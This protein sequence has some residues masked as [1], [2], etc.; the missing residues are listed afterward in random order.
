M[1]HA[2]TVFVIVLCCR[3]SPI[4]LHQILQNTTDVNEL[5]LLGRIRMA[6][7]GSNGDIPK[8]KVFKAYYI[9]CVWL[10]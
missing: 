3:A 7:P 9:A 4:I 6:E 5:S 10:E 8:Y 2:V 1:L